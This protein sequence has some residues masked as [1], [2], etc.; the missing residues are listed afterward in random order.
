MSEPHTPWPPA[1]ATN[2]L[3]VLVSGGIDSAVMLAEALA[4]YPAVYPV[5]VRSD[6]S[7]ETVEF[8]HLN[9]FLAALNRPNLKSRV[10]L[11]Q[12]IGDLYGTHWSLTG[13]NVPDRESPDEDVYLPGRNVLLLAKPL[14]WCHLNGV[15][16]LATAPLAGNPFPDA[17]STFYDGFAALVSR[18]VSGRV[19]VI[20][21]YAD[22]GLR[23]PDV[24]QRGKDLP[25]ELTFSCIR[26]V[27]SRHCGSCNK[28]A[29]RQAGFAAAAVPDPT[30]YATR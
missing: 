12:P 1:G 2:P 6:T 11:H 24:I 22:L 10:L 27:G 28:C 15:H 29:E 21:P 17:T 5:Y 20:R 14:V 8:D 25:L 9:R 13:E 23:K 4:V 26:P 30:E 3:A 18:A 19:R 7:W 16:E